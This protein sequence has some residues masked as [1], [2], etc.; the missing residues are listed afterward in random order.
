MFHNVSDVLIKLYNY[1]GLI[2]LICEKLKYLVI[3]TS[4]ISI[5]KR[6]FTMS[7]ILVPW[8]VNTM[9]NETSSR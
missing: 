6:T 1:R 3:K 7:Q 2:N 9:I 5:T 8:T 4:Q